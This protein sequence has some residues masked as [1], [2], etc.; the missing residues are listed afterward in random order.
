MSIVCGEMV[1]SFNGI[2]VLVLSIPVMRPNMFFLHFNVIMHCVKVFIK[3]FVVMSRSSIRVIKINLE[4]SM[5]RCTSN[6][7][8]KCAFPCTSYVVKL[9]IHLALLDPSGVPC[10]LSSLNYS[11]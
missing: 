7:F 5:S 10:C 1:H 9:S 8:L 6:S 3:L 2:F 11:G 4:T